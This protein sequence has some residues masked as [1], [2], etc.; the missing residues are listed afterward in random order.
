MDSESVHESTNKLDLQSKKEPVYV[1]KDL[2][3]VVVVETVPTP[4]EA[5]VSRMTVPA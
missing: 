5:A 2:F 3:S 4:V 1:D